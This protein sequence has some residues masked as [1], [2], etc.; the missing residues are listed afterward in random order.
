MAI[1]FNRLVRPGQTDGQNRMLAEGV[2]RVE[3]NTKRPLKT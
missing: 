2:V 1:R 3:I